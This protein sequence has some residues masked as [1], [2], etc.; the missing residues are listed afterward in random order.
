MGVLSESCKN[1]LPKPLKANVKE[2][3]T[4]S[5]SI[6]M[7]KVCRITLPQAYQSVILMRVFYYMA[8]LQHN[9]LNAQGQE[10]ANTTIYSKYH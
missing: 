7:V 5:S 9:Y 6:A 4:I 8:Q 1:L 10:G 3:K 2:S